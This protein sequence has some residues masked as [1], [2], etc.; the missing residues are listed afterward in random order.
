M[1]LNLYRN[2]TSNVHYTD[3]NLKIFVKQEEMLP[4]SNFHSFQH[5]HEEIE[6]IA[7]T[8]SKHMGQWNTDKRS[9][10][11]LPKPDDKFSRML[12]IRHPIAL[13]NGIYCVF[14]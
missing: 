7:S 10:I 3:D 13:S 14:L 12:L 11:V 8:I 6:M 1:T 5:I 2:Y 9:G 4:D